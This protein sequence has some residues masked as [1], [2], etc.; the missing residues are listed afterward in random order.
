MH[1]FKKISGIFLLLLAALFSLATLLNFINAIAEVIARDKA[2]TSYE[3]GY[4]MGTFAG[5][6][7][8]SALIFFMARFGIKLLKAKKEELETADQ[9]GKSL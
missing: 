8:F 1:I 7:I 3:L 5:L 6:L 9:I 4:T 2:Y